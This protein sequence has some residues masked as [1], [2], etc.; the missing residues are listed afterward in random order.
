MAKINS[1]TKGKVG[2]RCWRDFLRQNGY[3]DARRGQQFSGSNE[4]PDVVCPSLSW[5]HAEVKRVHAFQGYDW[6]NQATE[7]ASPG[8]IPYVAWRRNHTRWVVLLYAEDFI[9]LIHKA[10]RPADPEGHAS[11]GTPAKDG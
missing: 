11:H 6:L 1:R 9:R 8:Q 7:D 2:E 5:L 10:E 3:T 4:S